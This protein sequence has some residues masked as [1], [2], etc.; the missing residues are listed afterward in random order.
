[1]KKIK[2]Y[3]YSLHGVKYSMSMDIFVTDMNDNEF[4]V[5]TI[6]DIGIKTNTELDNLALE[7]LEELDYIL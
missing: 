1:M 7:I 2:N 3:S 4:I 6:S 5:A